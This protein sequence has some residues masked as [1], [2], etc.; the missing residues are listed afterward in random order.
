MSVQ[1]VL[2]PETRF[3]SSLISPFFGHDVNGL[4]RPEGLGF[5]GEWYLGLEPWSRGGVEGLP[6]GLAVKDVGVGRQR[7]E[8]GLAWADL[9]RWLGRM[10]HDGLKEEALAL[11]D[12]LQGHL[13][14]PP[15]MTWAANGGEY[16]LDF[17]R[18]CIMGILNLTPDSFSGDG[19]AGCVEEAVRRGV[20][21]VRQGADIID[22]GGESTRPGADAV[23]PEEEAARI[24]P[25]IAALAREVKVPVAVDTSKPEVMEVALEAGAA[26]I[27]DVSGLGG[28]GGDESSPLDPRKVK[29][30]LEREVPVIL[31]H[32]QGEPQVM[33]R[34]PHYRDVVW[35]VHR[36]LGRRVRECVQAGIAKKRLIVDVGFGF[37]KTSR[38]N[39]ALMQ[40]QRAF[41][42]LGVVL[43]FGVSRKRIVGLL[44]GEKDPK[45]RDVASHVLA[46]LGMLTGAMIFRVHDVLGAR[47]ALAAAWGW[48]H[49]GELLDT[50]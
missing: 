34:N 16:H 45:S 18:P 13:E 42:G 33:Q 25:V 12:A 27:N 14:G 36:F 47:Q 21:M 20:E 50:L 44:A 39:L 1:V 8:G 7:L 22:V 19:L 2:E 28:A 46:V 15:A 10:E 48:V 38:H 4:P 49:D 11:Q 35:D 6:A 26:M 23:A 3:S 41:R 9:M 24:V 43:L 31:M 17:S 5:A 40:R 29:L 37:G 32:R 30:L